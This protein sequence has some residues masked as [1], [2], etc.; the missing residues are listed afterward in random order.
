M[1]NVKKGDR[2]SKGGPATIERWTI[3]RIDPDAGMARVESVPMLA[4]RVTKGL[5]ESLHKSGVSEEADTPDLW[6]SGKIKMKNMTTKSLI[7]Q[8]MLRKDEEELLSENMVFWII[9]PGGKALTD[10]VYHATQAARFT[11]RNLYKKVTR[12]EGEG[13]NEKE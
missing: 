12:T 7:R 8:L 9:R 11:S 3:E 4:D 6:D 10:R 5:L 2:R 1:T 13:P